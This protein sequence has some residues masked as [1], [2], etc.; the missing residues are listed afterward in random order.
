M[1][2][3]GRRGAFERHPMGDFCPPNPPRA[4]RRP[5]RS[6]LAISLRMARQLQLGGKEGPVATTILQPV[7]IML[8]SGR[9]EPLKAGVHGAVLVLASVCAAYNTAA[10]LKRREP[11]L[12]VNAIIYTATV[13]WERCHVL[14]HMAACAPAEAIPA[15][16]P[17]EQ[18][19]D[20]A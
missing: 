1:A 4:A 8:D 9:C 19:D 18:L 17:E 7:T 12:A 5:G 13:W 3:A 14:H 15:V 2:L 6:C 16:L 11:H 10:W 20:A